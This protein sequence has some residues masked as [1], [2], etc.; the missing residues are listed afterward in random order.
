MIY[1][2]LGLGNEAKSV[3]ASAQERL[4]V[5]FE[6]RP[7]GDKNA[8]TAYGTPGLDL[9]A[10]VTGGPWRGLHVANGRL[11]GVQQN[12][13]YEV[14][15]DG[16]TQFLGS[17]LTST[18]Q[19]GMADNGLQLI[20]VDSYGYILNLTTNVLLQITS[21]GYP[22]NTTDV[23][24]QDGY[25]I[26]N[27]DNGQFYVSGILDGLTWDATDFATA[28]SNPDDLQRVYATNGELVLFGTLTTEFW[29]NSGGAQFPYTNL[30]GSTLQY[31]LAAPWALSDYDSSV[32]GLFR[33]QQ[34]G[35]IAG[36]LK[37]YQIERVSNPDVETKWETYTVSQASGFS[38]MLNGHPFWQLNFP[39]GSW[40]YDGLTGLWSEV[41][42]YG[43]ER[44]KANIGKL[45]NDYV[46]ADYFDGKLYKLNVNAYTDNGEVITRRVR[47]RHFFRESDLISVSALTLDMETGL[48]GVDN[49][50]VMLRVSKDGGHSWAMER[51]T[52]L[53][54]VGQ[55]RKRA[56]FR[57]LG[58]ARDWL[59]EV[60]VTDPVKFA[61]INA[62]V[63]AQ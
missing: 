23:T 46:V 42:G 59:F 44:H 4:N 19:V 58:I 49:P 5:Y 8:M 39:E 7:D 51:W 34:G 37:G 40:L 27:S 15:S 13:L 41:K 38:Y 24:Y 53:G 31:R 33:N 2:I 21:G 48:S 60:T 52:S 3:N 30:R 55:Y 18:G 10:E 54:S 62:Y 50:Q 36:V 25:F 43:L 20:I 1:G 12:S 47:G 63:D 16:T 9:F 11:F 22:A 6:P 61:L 29:G 57:R 28:E 56:R 14:F 17:I 45:W 32:I 26:V 35:L